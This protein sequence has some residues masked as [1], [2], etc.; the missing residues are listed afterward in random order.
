MCRV[1]LLL[2]K[3]IQVRLLATPG[4]LRVAR[5]LLAHW[6]SAGPGRMLLASGLS[7]LLG[8]ALG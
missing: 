5:N 2:S 6:F 1:G 3:R 4:W 8:E 7:L